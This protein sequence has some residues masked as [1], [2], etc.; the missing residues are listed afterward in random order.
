[1]N[2]ETKMCLCITSSIICITLFF[3]SSSCKTIKHYYFPS[4]CINVW[5]MLRTAKLLALYFVYL[6]FAMLMFKPSTLPI[7]NC[8]IVFFFKHRVLLC[9]SDSS[10]TPSV[11]FAD[12]NLTITPVTVIK[13]TQHYILL[14]NFLYAFILYIPEAKPTVR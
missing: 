3:D 6:F 8:K 13:G 14:C 12:P 7:L 4:F 9:S 10:G 1:M 2:P 5:V 11:E